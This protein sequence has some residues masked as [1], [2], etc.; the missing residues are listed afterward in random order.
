MTQVIESLA[1][2]TRTPFW[3]ATAG[4]QAPCPPLGTDLR[5]DLAIVGGGFTGLWTALEARRRLPDARIVLVDAGACGNA[6]SGR[7]GGFC[8]PSISHGIGNAMQRWPKEAEALVRLGISNL[9]DFEAD[10]AAY[11]MEVEFERSGKLTVAATPWQIEGLKAQQALR[12]RFGGES[13]FLVGDA[14]RARLDSP[15]YPAGLFEP[16]YALLNPARMVAELRR[17]ALASGV[18]IHEDTPVSGVAQ[19]ADGVALVTPGGRIAARQVVLATNAAPPLL[20]RLRGA[21]IPIFDYTIVTRPLADDELAAIGWTGRHGIADSGN[22]FHYLRKTA[23]NRILWGGFDAVY[24]YGSRRDAAFLTE[25]DSFDRLARNFARALPPLADVPLTHA[26]GGI[27]DTSARTTFFAGTAHG[28]RVAYA[29][30]FTGQGV[31]ASR[32]A[33]LTMLDLL[34]GRETERTALQMSRRSPVR[35]PPEPFRWLGIR[36]AQHG[37][38]REDATGRRSAFNKILDAFGVGFDS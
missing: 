26:W 36:M 3:A 12:R 32:F 5:C 33:A 27:I 7:N 14:L 8:A 22:Q 30:G 9:D 17:V 18:D 1:A 38:A 19:Q 16:N 35:F 13:E 24:H 4:P 28:G 11:G 37:L 21:A 15:V 10:L 29:M 31:S 25:S 20:R 34:Q 6:A 2:T 23:D